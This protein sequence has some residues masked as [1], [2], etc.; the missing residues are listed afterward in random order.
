MVSET[1]ARTG[2]TGGICMPGHPALLRR[3]EKEG[4][5]DGKPDTLRGVSSQATNHVPC[6][7]NSARGRYW[8]ELD[9]LGCM[10]RSTIFISVA[11]HDIKAS[12]G[13]RHSQASSSASI[14]DD[15]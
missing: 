1:S 11:E 8:G 12:G 3:E 5:L 7:S 9:T 6:P 14:S 15:S 13:R 2:A 4:G 10:L